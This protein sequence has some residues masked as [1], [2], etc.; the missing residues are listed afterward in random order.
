[1]CFF[2]WGRGSPIVL[3]A[4]SIILTLSYFN[5]RAHTHT[6]THISTYADTYTHTQPMVRWH[7]WLAAEVGIRAQ[8]RLPRRAVTIDQMRKEIRRSLGWDLQVVSRETKG[9]QPDLGC[10]RKHHL[11]FRGWAN[12]ECAAM[13]EEYILHLF[14]DQICDACGTLFS[15]TS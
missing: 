1:M 3:R 6:H 11:K 12:G 14:K 9:Q 5:P 4:D 2:G 15:Q 10:C 8:N 13:W 7:R